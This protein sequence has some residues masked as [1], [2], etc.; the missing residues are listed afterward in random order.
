VIVGDGPEEAHLKR[1]ANDLGISQFCTFTGLRF[2]VAE[3]L[4]AFDIFVL[5]SV[6]EGLPRVVIEAMVM[7]RPIVATDIN[8]VR[9]ELVHN[10]TGLLV[11]AGDPK[12]LGD[13]IIKILNDQQMAK[14]LGREAREFAKRVFD[15]RDT[16]A[17]VE[18]LYEEVFNLISWK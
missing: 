7:A 12:A 2:D 15:L 5:S 1:L 8:G 10:E 16:L 13:A 9:E 18:M 6:L 3:L 11:P 4:S 14:C 17:N